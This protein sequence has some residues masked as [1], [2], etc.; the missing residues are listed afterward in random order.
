MFEN[1]A[2]D[3]VRVGGF[4]IGELVKG[5]LE[6][7]GCY[8]ACFHVFDWRCSGGDGVELGEGSYRVNSTV[9]GEGF[10]FEGFDY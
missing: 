8:V 7:G 5:L 4:V 6:Y 2:R 9:R 3:I 1:D 10:S